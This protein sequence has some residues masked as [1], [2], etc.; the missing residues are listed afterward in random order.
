MSGPTCRSTD[1]E[2]A[3]TDPTSRMPLPGEPSRDAGAT[4]D[5]PSETGTFGA[6]VGASEPPPSSEAA[7]PPPPT[8]P[9]T[10]PSAEI[11]PPPAVSTSA[12]WRPPR[13][14]EGRFGTIIF[15]LILLGLGLWFFAE[16]TL[17]LELPTID[18]DQVWPIILIVI[19]LWIVLAARRR[20]SG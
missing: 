11:P 2:G 20:T 1:A 9:S 4:G 3:V 12:A 17:G 18:W 7:P 10:E 19:G 16:I 5:V 6:T 15:G 14:D 13:T 8:L